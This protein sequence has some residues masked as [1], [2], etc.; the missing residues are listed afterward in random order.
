MLSIYGEIILCDVSSCSYTCVF[1]ILYD[2]SFFF[3]IIIITIGT[4]GSF[5]FIYF[6]SIGAL[7]PGSLSFLFFVINVG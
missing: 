2:V 5:L 6:Y 3:L 1:F 4:F 7:G